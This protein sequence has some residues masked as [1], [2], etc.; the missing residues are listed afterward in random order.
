MGTSHAITPSIWS[1]EL[2]PQ[3]GPRERLIS[4]RRDRDGRTNRVRLSARGEPHLPGAPGLSI[5]YGPRGPSDAARSP[6]TLGTSPR[7]RL[8]IR[9]RRTTCARDRAGRT[10]PL[11]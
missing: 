8:G 6:G 1:M 7:H 3:T 9:G 4:L 10:A 2:D 5:A 11:P